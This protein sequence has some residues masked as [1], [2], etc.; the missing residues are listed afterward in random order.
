MCFSLGWIENI[1]IACVLIAAVVMIVRILIPWL[2]G[3][4][5]WTGIAEPV[6]QV[7]NI[8]IG[9]VVIIFLII[10]IFSL[11]SCAF[12]AGGGLPFHFR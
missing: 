8:V 5:G 10:L 7:L 6:M 11:L 9:A 2:L 1:L 12:G 3:L 4:V